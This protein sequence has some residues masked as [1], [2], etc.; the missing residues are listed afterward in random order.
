LEAKERAR[1][2]VTEKKKRLR[3]LKRKRKI[4]VDLKFR[5]KSLKSKKSVN[6]KL[7]KNKFNQS[8]KILLV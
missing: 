8:Q 2:E 6:I 3:N 5:L 7:K 1:K 4:R